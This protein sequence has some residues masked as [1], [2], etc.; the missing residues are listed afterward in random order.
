[1]RSHSITF[2]G[3]QCLIQRLAAIL[4]AYLSLLLAGSIDLALCFEP[5]FITLG[6][7]GRLL[8]RP[9][10]HEAGHAAIDVSFTA[11]SGALLMT[12]SLGIRALRHPVGCQPAEPHCVPCARGAFREVGLTPA[13]AAALELY[14]RN[15]LA[16]KCDPRMVE[17]HW[18]TRWWAFGALVGCL[19]WQNARWHAGRGQQVYTIDSSVRFVQKNFRLDDLLTSRILAKS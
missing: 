18:A 14:V 8:A 16:A 17:G 5:C 10:G 7:L 6:G 4:L 3:L 12:S 13:N 15:G 11:V 2:V 9:G 1:M 19:F